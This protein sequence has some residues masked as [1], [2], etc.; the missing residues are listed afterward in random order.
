MAG[1]EPA[2]KSRLVKADE[3]DERRLWIAPVI[4]SNM[5]GPRWPYMPPNVLTIVRAL[6]EVGC[7]IVRMPLQRLEAAFVNSNRL[8]IGRSPL[9]RSLLNRGHLRPDRRWIV[10]GRDTR[11]RRFG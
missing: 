2:Q 11:D 1:S 4:H 7:F 5:I 6:E 10:G 3:T 9:R 8:K